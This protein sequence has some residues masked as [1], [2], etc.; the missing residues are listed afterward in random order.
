M[1]EGESTFV[2]RQRVS[3]AFHQIGPAD[4]AQLA[5]ELTPIQLAGGEA[6]FRQGDPGDSL[7][8]VDHGRL[9]VLVRHRSGAEVCIAELGG[10]ELVGEGSLLTGAPRSATVVAIRDTALVRLSREGFQRLVASRPETAVELARKIMR[11]LQ[12]ASSDAPLPRPVSTVAVVRAGAAPA[13]EELSRLLAAEIGKKGEVLV[14]TSRAVDEALGPG[15]AQAPAAE[16]LGAATRRWLNDQERS[17]QLVVYQGD[18]EPTAWT[19]LCLRQADRVL[20]AARRSA[21]PAL[22][23]LERELLAVDAGFAKR[24]LV[25]L[26]DGGQKRPAAAW[27]E[28]RIVFRHHLVSVSSEA[29]KARLGRFLMGTATGIVFGGGGARTFAHLGALRAL[30]E[31]GVAIDAVGGC[32]G[33]SIFAAQ[34]A[35]DWDLPRMLKETRKGFLESGALLRPAI[36]MVSLISEKPFVRL[37]EGMFGSARIEDLRTPYFCVSTNLT[38]NRLEVHREGELR[39]WILASMAVPGLGPPVI[40]DGD[41]L[42]DG[43]V[44]SILPTPTM[45]ASGVGTVIGIDVAAR[46]GPTFAGVP[47]G[48]A[49]SGASVL[50]QRF[51]SGQ[52]LKPPSVVDLLLGAAFYG[53]GA[54]GEEEAADILVRPA[55]DA[56]GPLD[57]TGMDAIVAAG[58]D[59]TRA[60]LEQARLTEP[61]LQRA[62]AA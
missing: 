61:G 32:S 25:L 7:Y 60:S 33:G 62:S 30:H 27:L 50:F 12:S 10:L 3:K 45:R 31:E 2:R 44:A 8:V 22:N 19:R 24:E 15:H 38:R 43:C 11:R 37:V 39:T 4:L 48:V 20:L 1:T 34:Q 49:P 47:D 59:A 14:V 21:D 56:F 53:G 9:A 42:V 29:D 26:D 41:V 55:L 6:L 51:R 23:R 16:A 57:F 17:F 18:A 28:E 52:L 35:L 54:A 36:P 13:E 40:R 58:Y 5:V 46:T